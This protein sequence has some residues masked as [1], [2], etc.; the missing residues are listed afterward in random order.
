MAYTPHAP[1]SHTI[2]EPANYTR[3]TTTTKYRPAGWAW[4][5]SV[6]QQAPRLSLKLHVLGCGLSSAQGPTPEDLCCCH[7]LQTTNFNVEAWQAR[8]DGSYSSLR[9]NAGAVGDCRASQSTSNSFV[10]FETVAP[11][12]VGSMGGMGGGR[13]S[14]PYGPP[15]IHVMIQAQGYAP[16]L[17]DVPVSIDMATFQKSSFW[18]SDFRGAAWVRRPSDAHYRVTGWRGDKSRNRVEMDVDIMLPQTTTAGSSS[19][20]EL[21]PSIA[22]GLPSSFFF[23]PIAVCAPSM[24]NFF[25]L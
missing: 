13:D 15:V 5:R 17:V 19:R 25:A 22:Y 14:M 2:C 7:D 23:E 24:L 18:G 10:V 12:S 6:E 20:S 9:E 16:I 4:T 1:E 11:G 21:C 8:P 3:T